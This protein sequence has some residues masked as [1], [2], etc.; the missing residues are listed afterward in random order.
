[1]N[2]MYMKEL[3]VNVYMACSRERVLAKIIFCRYLEIWRALASTQ[4]LLNT[5]LL[6]FSFNENTVKDTK[7][8]M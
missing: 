7:K 5:P 3:D 2:S 8:F 4:V 1:M 6:T